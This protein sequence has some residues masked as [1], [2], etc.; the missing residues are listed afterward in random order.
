MELWSE[1]PTVVFTL[2]HG[3]W[4]S[5]AKWLDPD[6][7]FS[8]WLRNAFLDLEAIVPFYWSGRNSHSARRKAAEDLQAVLHGNLR[9]YP[10][11]KH[12]VIAHSHGG[13]I[14]MYA[15]RNAYLRDRIAGLICLSTPFLNP[16]GVVLGPYIYVYL[17]IAFFLLLAAPAAF[18]LHGMNATML[19]WCLVL[20]GVVLICV[21][22]D[23]RVLQPWQSHALKLERDLELPSL[24]K[25][26]LLVIRGL[27]DS[28]SGLLG[29]AQFLN[30]LVSA[31][32]IFLTFRTDE[33]F[34]FFNRLLELYL[35]SPIVRKLAK[36]LT[37]AVIAIGVVAGLAQYEAP[38]WHIAR[39]ILIGFIG[40][41]ALGFV[42]GAA[43]L[44][45]MLSVALLLFP[46]ILARSGLMLPFGVELALSSLWFGIVPEAT[47]AGEFT[48]HQ[49]P[50]FAFTSN[51]SGRPALPRVHATYED[52]R[53]F[54]IMGK[55]IYRTMGKG[56]IIDPRK[57]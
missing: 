17:I 42:I 5:R 8:E 43:L 35:K 49:L 55:W 22:L 14:A 18:V 38:G 23:L 11:A 31:T 41:F 6:S 26:Q 34:S 16:Q 2:V 51:E 27:G 37:P 33:L 30:W 15:L 28:A 13:N 25:D 3:T 21:A 46:L 47:P 54:E 9:R 53:C 48:I 10:N 4:G 40:L 50:S 19:A 57:D 39:A 7:A 45:L 44:V 52:S 56:L 20:F 24:D 29:A 32:W 36:R 1:F 12:F